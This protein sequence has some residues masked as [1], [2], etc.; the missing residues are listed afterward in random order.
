VPALN[1]LANIQKDDIV[2]Y[3]LSSFQLWDARKSPQTA[4]V[5]EIEP[6]HLDVHDSF[7]DYVDA[8]SHIVRFQ[9]EDDVVV[10]FSSVDGI[11]KLIAMQSKGKKIPYMYMTGSYAA[12]GYFWYQDEKVCSTDVLMLPGGHNFNNACAAIA[13]A[14]QYTQD[15]G[16]YS[17]GIAAFSGLPHRLKFVSEVNG[18]RFYDD[19]IATT[20]G[21]A[22]AALRAF[23][24]P[25][26][27]ILGG[28]D[29]GADYKELIGECRATGARVIAIGQTGAEIAR[30]CRAES[31]EVDELG[32]ASMEEIVDA[33]LK[34]ADGGGVVI[35]SPASASFDMF[36]NYSDRGEQ[37]VAAVTRREGQH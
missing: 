28:S 34:K 14:W 12:D 19:S 10:Y 22:I 11:P 23:E 17:K 6:D 15:K 18:V 9:T 25:K 26:V 8:K 7:E 24:G 21:S 16:A 3:E 29:K 31:V 33:A 13:A 20:S 27:I 1:A 5:L 32:T 2:V 36:K 4:V 37:F 30:L 35:L